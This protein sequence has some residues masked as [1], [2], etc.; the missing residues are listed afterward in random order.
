M[1]DGRYRE[2]EEMNISP[3]INQIGVI[4][5]WEKIGKTHCNED[6]RKQLT[7]KKADG[8]K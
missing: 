5:C 1:V 2:T 8:S 4:P 7:P 6:Q 3:I